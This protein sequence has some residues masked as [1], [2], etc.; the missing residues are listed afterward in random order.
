MAAAVPE[1]IKAFVRVR[2]KLPREAG[3][4]IQWVTTDNTIANV[5][6]SKSFAFDHVFSPEENNETVYDVIGREIVESAIQG[7]N[8]TIFAYGQ[9]G[10]GN[11]YFLT[12]S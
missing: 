5:D 12:C 6:G 1:A 8:A 11:F 3:A 7:I 2:Q 9:T 10:S 4:S